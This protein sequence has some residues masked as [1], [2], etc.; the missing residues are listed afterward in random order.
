[1]GHAPILRQMGLIPMY[2]AGKF[3]PNISSLPRD[4]G[5]IW[6]RANSVFDQG[7][8]VLRPVNIAELFAIWD[9]GVG[10]Q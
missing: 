8:K 4:Q 7:T 9:Y 5:V 10:Q 2:D 1:M 6:V 3:G